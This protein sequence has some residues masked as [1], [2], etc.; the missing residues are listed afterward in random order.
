LLAFAVRTGA[1]EEDIER[2]K[3]LQRIQR[4][5]KRNDPELPSALPRRPWK[6][7]EDGVGREEH[8]L[9]LVP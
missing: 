1:S 6:A 9:L 5:D 4:K 8:R 2:T 3:E 7:M